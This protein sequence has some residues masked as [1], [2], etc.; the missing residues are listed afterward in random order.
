MWEIGIL[1]GG[2]P[3]R[4]GSGDRCRN[5]AVTASDVTDIGAVFVA[6]PFMI[7]RKGLWYLF[8]E[9]LR[10]DNLLGEIG[11]AVSNDLLAW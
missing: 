3:L 1:A 9:V 5:P 4:L 7:L 10:K 11:L 8:F 6:D 2:S